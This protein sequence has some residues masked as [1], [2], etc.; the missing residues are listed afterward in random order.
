MNELAVFI[1]G[2]RAGTVATRR[3]ASEFRYADHYL[4]R[5]QPTPLSLSVPLTADSHPVG[6]WL[7]GLLPDND[8]VRRE[9]ADLSGARDASPASLLGTHIGLDCAGSVQFCPAVDATVAR[10]DS[11]FEPQTAGDI[12][13]WIRRAREAWHNSGRIGARGQFSLSG[14]QAK[15]ALRRDGDSWAVPYG[16]TPTTHIVKPGMA[17]YD[18]ADLVEHACLRAA[19]LAGLDAAGSEIMRFEGERAL[20]VE[21]FDRAVRGGELVRLHHEDLCQALAVAPAKKYQSYGGPAPQQIVGLLRDESARPRIDVQRFVDALVFNWAI[22][23]TDAHAK[24]YSVILDRGR[25]RLAPLY[26]VISYLPY[27]TTP[28]DKIRTAMRIG[29]DY[30]LRKADRPSAWERTAES[31]RLDPAVTLE[32]AADLLRRIPGA[33]DTAI[34]EMD[35]IDQSSPAVEKLADRLSRRADR[36]RVDFGRAARTAKTDGVQ[37][38]Q[39]KPHSDSQP[40]SGPAR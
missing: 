10:R 34:G 32:R 25:V 8:E 3:G 16:D 15:Y 18:D 14:A 11:G 27:A 20:V 37:A 17:G 13:A 30:T 2:Q 36:L 7:D 19:S 1:D 22:A 21:R 12:A 23:A 38:K 4:N 33:L 6:V 26:D 28:Q 40:Q 9:W 5:S 24:N 29:R 39:T 35:H 31:L